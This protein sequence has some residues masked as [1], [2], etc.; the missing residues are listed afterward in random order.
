MFIFLYLYAYIWRRKWRP[1]LVFLPGESQGRE[2]G[3]PPSMGLHRVGNDWRD[4]AAV[5]AT[6]LQKYMY[7]AHT[8]MF[9][10]MS[11]CIVH[12]AAQCY[13]CCQFHF[14]QYVLKNLCLK[15]LRY[16]LLYQLVK[17][18]SSHFLNIAPFSSKTCAIN[19]M[20]TNSQFPCPPLFEL[21]LQ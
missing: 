17:E 16:I 11:F 15:R 7:H 10:G 8:Q 14:I 4:L 1:T 9:Y 13:V 6:C 21:F 5:A 20:Y 2:P 12:I 3:G 18:V 19:I